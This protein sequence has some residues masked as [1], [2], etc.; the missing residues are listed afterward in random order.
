MKFR[1]ALVGFVIS[2]LL[3]TT[4]GSLWIRS[5]FAMDAFQGYWLTA[6]AG[7]RFFVFSFRGGQLEF[8][9]AHFRILTPL[10]DVGRSV[11]AINRGWLTYPSRSQSQ[12]IPAHG[13]LA[14]FGVWAELTAQGFSGTNSSPLA[15]SWKQWNVNFPLWLPMLLFTASGWWCFRRLRRG[16]ARALFALIFDPHA[17]VPATNLPK[18]A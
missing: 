3:F 4:L 16:R 10:P 1:P 14:R 5:Y 6:S 2:L 11:V 12:P 9:V 15:T 17:T 13:L 7:D 8:C 18:T